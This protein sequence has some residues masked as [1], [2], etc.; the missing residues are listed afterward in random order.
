MTA[1]ALDL[2]VDDTA[3]TLLKRLLGAREFGVVVATAVVVTACAVLADGFMT[4]ANLLTV[5]QQIAV[6]GIIAVGMTFVLIA[7]EIDLSVG[8]L[9]GF[10]AVT[11]ASLVTEI[12]VPVGG[13]VPLTIGVGVLIGLVNGLVT[14]GL[15]IPSFIVTLAAMGVLR[16][17]ALLIAD[18]VPVDGSRDPLFHALFAGYPATNLNASTLWMGGVVVIASVVLAKTEFGYDVYATG[19]NSSAAGNAGIGTAR[20]KITCFCVSGALCGLAATVINAQFG[21]APPSTGVGYELYAIAAVV[22]GGAALSGGTGSILG[23]LLGAVLTG[24]ISNA[25]VLFG[26]DDN[27]QQVA[28][29]LLILVAVLVNTVIARRSRRGVHS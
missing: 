21:N 2:P 6:L 9:Y 19:G 3:G 13:A 25:L 23:A 7:G 28:T 15:G 11:L 18:D 14:T 12:G 1:H 17:F 5:A 26:I 22:I 8:S 29:G 27:W 20:V 10:L 16:G 4:T 24:V